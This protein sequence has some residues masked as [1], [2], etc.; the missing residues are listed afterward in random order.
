MAQ[1][2]V[3]SLVC[4]A[5]QAGS[6]AT[7]NHA[8]STHLLELHLIKTAQKD[9]IA[10]AIPMERINMALTAVL[11]PTPALSLKT[12]AS[13]QASLVLTAIHAH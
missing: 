3:N 1:S 2:P 11:A 10:R 13:I 4:L 6:A 7:T 9:V 5:T 12:Q 8:N